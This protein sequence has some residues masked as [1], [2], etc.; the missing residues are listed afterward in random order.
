MCFL[1]K[2]NIFSNKPKKAFHIFR[3]F[4]G[5]FSKIIRKQL[6]STP[7][8][9]IISPS[10]T[11]NGTGTVNSIN[12]CGA[13]ESGS[14]CAPAIRSITK[15]RPGSPGDMISTASPTLVLFRW[16]NAAVPLSASYPQQ[17]ARYTYIYSRRYR[18]SYRSARCPTVSRNS[19]PCSIHDG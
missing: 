18:A 16:M 12:G 14:P 15:P 11:A 4:P 9:R 19:I 5:F 1:K 10:L 6:Y 7:A 2:I 3:V 17:T 13:E 8:L